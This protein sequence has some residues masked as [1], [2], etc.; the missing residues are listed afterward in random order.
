MTLPEFETLQ[1]SVDKHIAHIR[2]NRPGKAN[3]INLMM[4][5]E[6]RRAFDWID[7]TSQAR[8]AVISAN[9]TNFTSGIDLAML[10]GVI[11]FAILDVRPGLRTG[12]LTCVAVLI[13][14]FMILPA[15]L[16]VT[17]RKWQ[18]VVGALVAGAI[19]IVAS[20][21]VFGVGTWVS[22]LAGKTA[23]RIPAWQFSQD[24]NQSLLGVLLRAT[25][26]T[27]MP[28]ENRAVLIAYCTIAVFVVIASLIVASRIA[29]NQFRLAYALVLVA[30][31]IVYPGTIHYYAA[32]LLI[33]TMLVLESLRTSDI[34][35]WRRVAFAGILLAV[36]GFSSFI[37]MLFSWG[38]LM[39]LAL[40][41]QAAAPIR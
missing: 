38:V 6:I 27:G 17:T 7:A 28:G 15:L 36:V 40:R 37:A 31:M 24:V 8:V 1:L 4:W 22:F 13:K 9:G 21:A 20:L 41:G 10:A 23:A 3:A 2:I 33:P 25:G 14:P 35:G 30:A 5:E 12:M 34:G 19:L 16:L 32:V 29:T 39:Q 26:A 18:A 11:V